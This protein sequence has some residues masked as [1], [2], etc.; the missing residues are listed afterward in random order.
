MEP[1]NALTA[2][3]HKQ[4]CSPL[5]ANPQRSHWAVGESVHSGKKS[6]YS[7]G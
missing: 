4:L 1:F 6:R 5:N 7:E 2:R 3:W